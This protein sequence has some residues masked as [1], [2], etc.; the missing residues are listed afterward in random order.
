MRADRLIQIIMLLQTRGKIKAQSLAEE[1]EVS[2]RTIL[3]DID[4]LSIAGIPVYTDSG[5]GG[6]ISL[7]ETYRSRLTG[8]KE[9]EL[10]TLL[11]AD[12]TRIL[13]ELGLSQDAT[14]SF[15]KLLAGLPSSQRTTIQRVRQRI[16][17]DPDWWF[18]EATP[19]DFWDSLYQAVFDNQMISIQYLNYQGEHNE[20]ILEPYSLVSK[21]SNWYLV[22][23][24]DEEFRVYRVSRIQ[25]LKVLDQ[26]F[27][28]ELDFDLSSFWKKHSLNFAQ[29]QENYTF[30]LKVHQKQLTFIKTLLPGRTHVINEE[31]DWI[32]L[33]INVISQRFARMLIFELGMD[34]EI[35]EPDELKHDMLNRT[36]NLL[37]HLMEVMSK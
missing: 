25:S 20:R 16:L 17:I 5:H 7:H 12:N 34:A 30:V 33:Q 22:A 1:L 11:I 6:G 15:L 36:Q 4:A 37:E 28:Y 8:L 23:R 9:L 19:P 13:G 18:H 31:E 26:Y 3:R 24:R 2:R 21:S 29:T 35:I 14:R 32:T 10:L 27:E